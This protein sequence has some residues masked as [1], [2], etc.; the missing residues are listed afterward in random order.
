MRYFIEVKRAPGTG[1]RVGAEVT[2]VTL[3]L[4]KAARHRVSTKLRKVEYVEYVEY[5]ELAWERS[6]FKRIRILD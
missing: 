2:E 4:D 1:H 6:G 3:N 5:V